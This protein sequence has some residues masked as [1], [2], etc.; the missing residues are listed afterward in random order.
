MNWRQVDAPSTSKTSPSRT[1]KKSIKDKQ[2]LKKHATAR[3][4]EVFDDLG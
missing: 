2:L 3:W 4:L 1:L